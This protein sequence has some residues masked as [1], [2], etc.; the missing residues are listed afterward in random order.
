MGFAKAMTGTAGRCK[1]G[2]FVR[3]EYGTLEEG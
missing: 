2:N 3:G 1:V